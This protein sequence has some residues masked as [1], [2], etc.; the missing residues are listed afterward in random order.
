M[1]QEHSISH[2]RG[3]YMYSL[4]QDCR[5]ALKRLRRLAFQMSSSLL[6]P[7]Q[8]NVHYSGA[9]HFRHAQTRSIH[10]LKSRQ[11]RY[12][13]PNDSLVDLHIE[14]QRTHWSLSGFVRKRSVCQRWRYASGAHRRSR[15]PRS[16]RPGFPIRAEG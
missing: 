1:R 4:V 15:F 12:T 5:H 2:L 11:H 7:S 13:N 3:H 16:E 10:V 9:N 14:L 6:S 8:G